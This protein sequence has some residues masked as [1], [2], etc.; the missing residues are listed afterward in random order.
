MSRKMFGIHPC[1]AI[2]FVASLALANPAW[3]GV[4]EKVLYTF[5]GANGADPETKLVYTASGALFGTAG[6]GGNTTTCPN[7]NGCGVVFELSTP[8][9]G[10]RHY[11]L[12][13][14]FNGGGSDGMYPLGNIVFDSAEN[15]YGVTE[16]GGSGDYGCGTV[17]KL[18]PAVG[19]QW[20]ETVIHSFDCDSTDGSEPLAGLVMDAAG[21]LYGTTGFGGTTGH[22][23]V[24]ELSPNSEG[25]WSETILY[26]F[27]SENAGGYEPSAELIIDPAGNLYGSTTSGG[28]ADYGTVFELFNTSD[29]WRE[30]V[31]YNP[32]GVKGLGRPAG[33]LWRDATGNLYGVANST[34]F[35][36]GA[37]FEL[38]Q[39]A[40]G[41]WTESTLHEF[42]I[43][44]VDGNEPSSGLAVDSGGSMYGTT[45][46]GGTYGDY[47]TVYSLTPKTEGGWSYSQIYSFNGAP[48]FNPNC[49]ITLGAANTLYGVTEDDSIPASGGAYEIVF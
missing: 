4:H 21:N 29:G 22:G 36:G 13:Y 40:D 45:T 33:P 2:V 14:V 9:D 41:S 32:S 5:G 28:T 49:G 19:G 43:P 44:P 39:N 10:V 12:L 7:P 34:K 8:K 15:L 20:T 11:H 25:S 6:V 47:G 26:N 42:G 17:Y 48:Q 31:L 35:A 30:D 23:T 18:S 38:T 24:Y 3:A 1:A 37:V 27:S 46:A 16:F